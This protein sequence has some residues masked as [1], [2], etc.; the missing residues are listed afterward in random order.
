MMLQLRVVYMDVV[1]V[2]V[3]S[4][5]RNGGKPSHVRPQAPVPTP[6]DEYARSLPAYGTLAIYNSSENQ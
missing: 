5:V 2:Q 6:P 1:E 3:H 4:G